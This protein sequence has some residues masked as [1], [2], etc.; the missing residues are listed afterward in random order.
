MNISKKYYKQS[1]DICNFI[2]TLIKF[3]FTFLSM[4]IFGICGFVF[5]VLFKMTPLWSVV[6]TFSSSV[7]VTAYLTWFI[8]SFW[9][10]IYD[11]VKK[12]VPS[13]KKKKMRDKV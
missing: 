13:K 3:L 8:T 11:Y 12:Y 1:I 2:E 7:F 10:F 9:N 5:T 4:L 6:I